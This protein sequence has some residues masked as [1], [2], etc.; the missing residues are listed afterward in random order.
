MAASELSPKLRT[1]LSDID[2][3][4]TPRE[5]RNLV[6]LAEAIVP[7]STLET[8]DSVPDLFN[9]LRN[10]GLKETKALA[11]LKRMLEKAYFN[12]R[13]VVKLKRFIAEEDETQE[14]SE[15][16]FRE[17]IVLVSN[18]LGDGESLRSLLHLITDEQVGKPRQ[19]VAT[20]P[21]LFHRLIHAEVITPR[22]PQTLD[23][24]QDWMV[25]I[26]RSDI[27]S[28]IKNFLSTH[29]G[30][31]IHR[32]GEYDMALSCDCCLLR[33]LFMAVIVVQN[34]G[35]LLSTRYI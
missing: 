18:K 6:I 9:C 33:F 27:A 35:T 7:L 2:R 8:V 15:L 3:F 29:P 1:V 13:Y 28:D 31:S 5:F 21:E 12:H 10:R 20:A 14:H 30:A 34:M 11:V 25:E 23:Q 4:K 24:L 16:L 22:Q 26:G 17:L 19:L 32:S